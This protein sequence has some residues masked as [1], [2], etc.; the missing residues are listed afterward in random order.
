MSSGAIRIEAPVAARLRGG[1]GG[2]L[3]L[4]SR[5]LLRRFVQRRIRDRKNI[6]YQRRTRRRRLIL[7]KLHVW[8]NETDCC[9][10]QET[11][12]IARNRELERGGG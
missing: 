5:S 11:G 8:T 12:R 10:S 9:H 2:L 7:G 4:G 3:R 6:Q 1:V